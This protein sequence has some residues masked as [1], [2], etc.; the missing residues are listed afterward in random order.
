MSERLTAASPWR[1]GQDDDDDDGDDVGG[2]DR[3][4]GIKGGTVSMC[5]VRITFG[6]KSP[7]TSSSSSLSSSLLSG[8]VAAVEALPLG[9][10]KTLNRFSLPLKPGGCGTS[11]RITLKPCFLR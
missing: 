10:A 5:E 1:G 4:Y 9:Q 11:C 2:R 6:E 8:P 7:K 3:E